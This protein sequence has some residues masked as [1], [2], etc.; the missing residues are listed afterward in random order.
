MK[1]KAGD[2][3]TFKGCAWNEPQWEFDAPI[4]LYSPLQRYDM[5]SV[6]CVDLYDKIE[7]V[8]ID[9]CYNVPIN[10]HFDKMSLKEFKW[11]GWNPKGFS[12]RKNAVHVEVTVEF[13]LDNDNELT[14][15]QLAAAEFGRDG[16]R[17]RLIGDLPASVS[18]D[19]VLAAERFRRELMRS[20]GR[21]NR[22]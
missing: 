8:C 1:V 4:V 13:F 10:T 15:R 5:G 19:K 6:S 2:I 20:H 7:D 14:F 11:R 21:K 12:R 22:R 9:L 3:V 16:K 17:S 18:R